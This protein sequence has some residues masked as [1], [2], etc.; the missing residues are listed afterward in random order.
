VGYVVDRLTGDDSA[1]DAGTSLLYL[2]V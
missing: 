2:I 1:A